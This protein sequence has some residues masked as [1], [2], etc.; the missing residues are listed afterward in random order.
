MVANNA[1]RGYAFC[2]YITSYIITHM[3]I[4]MHVSIF[5]ILTVLAM[6]GV[7]NAGSVAPLNLGTAARFAVLAGTGISNAPKST[8][9]GDVGVSPAGRATLTGFNI[10]GTQEITGYLFAGD[11]ISPSSVPEMLRVAKND[12]S[13]AYDDA[14]NRAMTGEISGDIGG[15]TFGPGV[16][17]SS[18]PIG[19]SAGI[20]TLNGGGDPNAV[21]IFKIGGVFTIAPGRSIVLTGGAQAQ[22]VF[23]QVAGPATL[24]SGIIFN[25][26]ILADQSITL[27]AATKVNGR[28]FSRNGS[29]AIA[30]NDIQIP[31]ES[32]TIPTLMTFPGMAP[33]PVVASAP[34]MPAPAAQPV[35]QTASANDQ[36]AALLAMLA[37]L[38]KQ[39]DS[40]LVQAPSAAPA[41]ATVPSA[42]V[43]AVKALQ[44]F[45]NTHGFQIAASG[46]GS[47]GNE[48]T[49]LGALTRSALCK[50]QVSEG[51]VSSEKSSAC[52]THGPK[53]K[54]RIKA[55]SNN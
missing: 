44:I 6:T 39:V 8:I 51:I 47:P 36:L 9:I 19:F 46:P 52:G 23:W 50:F 53:T 22:N 16:Y 28:A 15:K 3:N 2:D 14:G 40:Q 31:I 1:N 32:P 5:G 24:G 33:A 11:D 26:N 18:G 35:A 13:S 17:Q 42:P 20:V 54:A 55:M 7:A 30:Y 37:D 29:V 12:L 34:V 4:A 43:N 45:L 38:Q 41:P 49:K 10:S 21:W 27:G 48:T 25:G